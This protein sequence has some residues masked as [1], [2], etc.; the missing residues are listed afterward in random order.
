MKNH[1]ASTFTKPLAQILFAAAFLLLL[2]APP[3]VS[4]QK[5][6][7]RTTVANPGVQAQPPYTVSV[8]A[9]SVPGVY[10]QP[11]SITFNSSAIFIGYGNGGAPNG[12]TA[13]PSTIVEYD[14]NGNVLNQVFVPGHNDGLKINPQTGDLW[15]LQ[16][17]DGNATLVIFTAQNLTPRQ[18]YFLGTGPHGGGYDDVVFLNGDVYISASSP[19]RSH[20]HEYETTD[21]SR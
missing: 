7:S 19:S 20:L 9:Q 18:K 13:T 1:L 10:T 17:E 6:P 12:M 4:A 15:S 16:N 2:V 8:F 3:V 5:V 14:F 11:D 21:H